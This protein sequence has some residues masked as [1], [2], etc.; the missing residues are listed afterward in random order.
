MAAHELHN[1]PSSPPSG[2]QVPPPSLLASPPLLP[3][4]ELLLAPLLLLELLLAPLLLPSSLTPPSRTVVP[5]GELLLLQ[6]TAAIEPAMAT[7]TTPVTFRTFLLE[8]ITQ[9]RSSQSGKQG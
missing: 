9:P 5:L 1:A 7:S 8:F 4:L 3:L 6:A 2:M